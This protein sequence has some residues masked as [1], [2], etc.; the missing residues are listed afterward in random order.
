MADDEVEQRRRQALLDLVAAAGGPAVRPSYEARKRDAAAR[1]AST[2]EAKK[3]YLTPED[4]GR[5][6]RV[7]W[8]RQKV[9]LVSYR[10]STCSKWHLTKR[11]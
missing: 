1:Q 10:C 8:M 9:R 2:C 4:A 3:A 7:T 11:A 5:A 6:A